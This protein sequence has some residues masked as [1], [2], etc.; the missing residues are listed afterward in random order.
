MRKCRTGSVD[1]AG[2]G[3]VTIT[4][5]QSLVAFTAMAALLTVTPG[6]DTALVLR[7]A[8][9]EG[10][11]SALLAGAGICLGCLAWGVVVAIGLGALITASEFAYAVL[12]IVGAA[13][14][15]YL[16]F[17][18][19]LQPT[20][21]RLETAG[22]Q[23]VGGGTWLH[24]GFFTNLLNPKVGL[25][26]TAF[27]PQFVPQGV[28]VT[29][30]ILLLALIHASLGLLWFLLLAQLAASA[31]QFLRGRAVSTWL[32][33]TLGGLLLFLGVRLLMMVRD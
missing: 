31:G 26:Y 14:L 15:L 9:M 28:G 12:K 24:R 20:A 21:T 4:V 18:V 29:G 32:D 8:T 10:R 17:K 16:G 33:R 11:R 19:I 3:A 23:L 30:F 27:L 5:Q 2:G 6:L 25:F 7:A 13:Y 1:R 22:P